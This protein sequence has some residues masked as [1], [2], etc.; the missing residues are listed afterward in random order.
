MACPNKIAPS[1]RDHL[2]FFALTANMLS[3]L[4]LFNTQVLPGL[5]ATSDLV[6]DA[7]ER[8]LITAIN[9]T[10]LTPFRFQGW[11]GKRLTVSFGWSY[12]FDTHKAARA[13]PMPGWLLPMRTRMAAF[14]GVDPAL[15]IQALLIRY[16]P[17]AGI[18]WHRDR[19]I[20]EHVVGLSLGTPT[21]MRF[22]RRRP[23]GGFDRATLPL[24]PRA[25]YH[26]VDEA[27]HDWEHSIA[28]VVRPRWSITFRSASDRG[29]AVF[30]AKRALTA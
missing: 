9:A 21:E 20:Y 22:R 13:E 28:E 1:D 12:D 3:M 15:L 18:G 19:P 23:G 26:L 8:A 10:S 16:D 27:R 29:Q 14:A 24:D 4:D 6:T 5:S 25:A 2:V 17:G 30:S 11:E 7:E